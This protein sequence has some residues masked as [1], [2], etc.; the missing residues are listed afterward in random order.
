VIDARTYLRFCDEALVAMRDIV[1]ELG[2]DLANR[3]PDLPGANT[4][5]AILT[6]C[7]GVTARWAS[8]VNLGEVVPRDRDAEFTASGAVADLATDTD[9]TR[10][11]LQD[12]VSRS[13]L[14]EP[15]ANPTHDRED[16]YAATQGGVLMHVYEELAQHRGQLELTRDVLLAGA[17]RRA[18]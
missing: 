17:D 11:S 7:L 10:I 4:P 8:T 5:F 13:T 18:H 12:W 6:H 9:R 1:V 16:W 15:P 3:R 2:D 14:D